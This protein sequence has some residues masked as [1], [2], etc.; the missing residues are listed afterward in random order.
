MPRSVRGERARICR[1]PRA[2]DRP[3]EFVHWLERRFGASAGPAGRPLLA[4]FLK[5][6]GASWDLATYPVDLICSGT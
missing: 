6:I 4:A 2:E 1:D 3:Y 5:S